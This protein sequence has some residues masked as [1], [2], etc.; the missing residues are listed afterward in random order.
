[1]GLPDEV[2]LDALVAALTRGPTTVRLFGASMKPL[3]WPGSL[4]RLTPCVRTSLRPGDVAAVRLPGSLVVHR[5][6]T[7]EAGRLVLAG[8]RHRTQ[9][10]VSHGQLL[11]RLV[12]IHVGPL[13]WSSPPSQ[14]SEA[15]HHSTSRLLRSTSTARRRAAA[16]VAP[17]LRWA[18]TVP[19]AVS[20]RRRLWRFEIRPALSSDWPEIRRRLLERGV[21][22]TA[23]V[24][25]TWERGLADGLVT[26]AEGRSRIVAWARR[27]VPGA[28]PCDVWVT[29]S[30]RGLALEQALEASTL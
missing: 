7:A 26:V 27:D 25:A 21:R 16:W 4:A 1:M 22:P 2:V 11:G 19:L 15:W 8:D 14:V 29:R 18:A 5:V 10:D 13:V 9:E 28:P 20:A 3:M 12:S 17:T 24:V 30:A 6:V 23:A